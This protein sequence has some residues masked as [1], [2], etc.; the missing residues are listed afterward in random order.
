MTGFK[1][2][3]CRLAEARVG[4][5]T[6]LGKLLDWGNVGA[7]AACLGGRSFRVRCRIRF[8][9]VLNSG[10]GGDSDLGL[11]AILFDAGQR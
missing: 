7:P 1:E 10:C 11:G 4:W 5:Q 6:I 3:V 9:L 8:A 2:F